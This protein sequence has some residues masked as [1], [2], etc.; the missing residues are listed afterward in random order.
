[1]NVSL[2]SLIVIAVLVVVAVFAVRFLAW[3]IGVLILAAAVVFGLALASDMVTGGHAVRE[4]A[5]KF[6]PAIAAAIT[7]GV[8]WYRA[9]SEP[10]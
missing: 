10:E 9:Q 4:L 1:M 7:A 6:V 8:H 2:E 5:E 3:L